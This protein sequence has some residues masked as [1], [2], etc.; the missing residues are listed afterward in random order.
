[1][2]RVHS[3][4]SSFDRQLCKFIPLSKQNLLTDLELKPFLSGNL[5]FG[6]KLT[7]EYVFLW[8]IIR[9]FMYSALKSLMFGKVLRGKYEFPASSF[10]EK[11]SVGGEAGGQ[12]QKKFAW[13]KGDLGRGRWGQKNYR[14]NG[15]LPLPIPIC[16]FRIFIIKNNENRKLTSI[17]NFWFL[18]KI[19]W[20]NDTRTHH[21]N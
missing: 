16:H 12:E 13:R 2:S 4:N 18:T 7:S 15:P 17:F 1:M 20:T 3:S 8:V 10:P 9:S 19:E 14:A 5:S 11:C 6:N 21:T